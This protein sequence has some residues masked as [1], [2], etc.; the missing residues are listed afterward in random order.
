MYQDFNRYKILRMFFDYPNK[1]FQLRE[2]ERKTKISLP[3]VRNHVKTL[4]KEG[5]VKEVKEGVYNGYILNDT[6]RTRTYKRNDL[7]ARL[8]D[9]GIVDEIERKCRPNCIVLYGSAV[10][11]R[12]DERG[13]IDLFV[14]AEEREIDLGRYEKEFNRKINIIFEPKS[15][16]LNKELINS[17]ANGITLRGFLKV[18]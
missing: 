9:S 5:F 7:L 15:E 8:Q 16:K 13:D 3:S 6:D 11:G 1:K 14:Q 2:L 4:E 18:V 17:L 12:D 10:E